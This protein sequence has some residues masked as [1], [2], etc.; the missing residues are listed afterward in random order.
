[1]NLT[2]N[3][4]MNQ[5][6][7][8]SLID[9]FGRSV[10][11]LRLSVTDRCNLRCV[12]CM[13]EDMTFLKREEV[14]SIEEL[15]EVGA[16]FVEL[17]VKKIRLT[18]G[19]PLVRNGVDQLITGLGNLEGLDELTMTSNGVLLEKHLPSMLEAGIKRLNI[20]L[21]SLDRETF[22]KLGRSDQLP[23]VLSGLQ[24]VKNAGLKVRLNSV[25]LSGENHD[26]IL[27][28]V[29]YAVE[30]GFDIAFIEEMPLGNI[31]SHQRA[32]TVT[33][34]DALI[35]TVSQCYELVQ[36]EE[37]FAINA[38][39]ARYST[40]KGSQ[41]RIGFISPHSN[42]FCGSCNRVRVTVE[43]QLLLC[44]GNEN[45]IDLRAVLRREGYCREQLKSAILKGI[46]NKPEK[47]DFN[48]STTHIVRFMNMTGG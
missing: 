23:K 41:S 5:V 19:E 38:G 40:I 47:H 44:L 12:Y 7:T 37:K 13:A 3:A 46:Q 2:M 9:P 4:N 1:M 25:I 26:S 14:L 30:N 21:D 24:A 31:S 35:Q 16:A 22:A 39:P 18:G 34:N 11:Y 43:G 32:D 15:H 29:D 6:I 17:G 36:P 45:A 42:N 20:S 27:P 33:M 10:T 28:L 48:V 8:S